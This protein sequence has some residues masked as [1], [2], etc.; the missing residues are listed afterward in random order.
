MTIIGIAA[1]IAVAF[2]SF[3]DRRRQSRS[4]LDRVGF[5]PWPFIAMMGT[6]V[7]LFAFAIALRSAP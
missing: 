1:A 4:E 2:A 3:A 6:L 5:M 7:A